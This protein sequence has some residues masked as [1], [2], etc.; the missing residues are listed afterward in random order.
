HLDG[1]QDAGGAY[2]LGLASIAVPADLVFTNNQV[3]V[4]ETIS[5]LG[6]KRYYRFNGTQSEL[7]DFLIEHTSGD[8]AVRFR[9][10]ELG[11]N[12]FYE[13]P[14]RINTTTTN[15]VRSRSVTDFEIT[16]T[17]SWIIEVDPAGSSP[18]VL[19]RAKGPFS[20]RV[21]RK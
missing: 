1:R 6:E 14:G 21:D 13:L 7:Y 2:L 9:V 18:T 4:N 19:E 5:I 17:D 20:L 8:L 15:S 16:V 10:G 11:G 12:M 3:S